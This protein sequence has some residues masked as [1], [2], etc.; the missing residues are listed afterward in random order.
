MYNTLTN[1]MIFLWRWFTFQ[2]WGESWYVVN[3]LQI[4]ENLCES[5]L[6]INLEIVFQKMW[7]LLSYVTSNDLISWILLDWYLQN[8][9]WDT[10]KIVISLGKNRCILKMPIFGVVLA[11]QAMPCWCWVIIIYYIW[12]GIILLSWS[13]QDLGQI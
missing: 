12:F 10:L 3:T 8:Y 5:F 1:E 11:F 2:N 7:L 9:F 13:M 6:H 4:L